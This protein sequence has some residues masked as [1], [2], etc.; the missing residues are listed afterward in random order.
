[1]R[2]RERGRERARELDRAREGGKFVQHSEIDIC[3]Y[4]SNQKTKQNKKKIF[5]RNEAAGGLCSV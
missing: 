4:P 2:E 3:L 5:E 1:M